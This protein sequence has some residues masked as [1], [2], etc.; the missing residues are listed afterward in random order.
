LDASDSKQ[1]LLH[2]DRDSEIYVYDYVLI[3]TVV[4]DDDDDDDDDEDDD[5]NELVWCLRLGFQM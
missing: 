4:N 3:D 1:S 5:D 2:S